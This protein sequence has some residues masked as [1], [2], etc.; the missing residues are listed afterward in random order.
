MRTLERI[1][2]VEVES[3]NMTYSLILDKTSLYVLHEQGNN[4]HMN[5]TLKDVLYYKELREIFVK[6]LN[7]DEWRYPCVQ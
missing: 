1:N 7:S 2:T 6:L 3:N 5:Y 4:F